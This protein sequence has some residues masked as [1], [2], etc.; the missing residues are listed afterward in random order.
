M[1]V[2]STKCQ[3]QSGQHVVLAGRL[4]N[5]ELT[6]VFINSI[7]R[8]RQ[9]SRALLVA[10]GLLLFAAESHAD[11]G[12]YVGGS[13]GQAGI[14]IDGGGP[15][16][17]I[18]FDEEDFAWKVFGGY[19]FDLAVVDLGIEI[20]Y[21]DLGAPSQDVQG[22]QVELEADGIDAFGVV[23]IALGPIGVF[24]KYG[25]IS[26]DAQGTID[27]LPAFDDDGSDPAYGVGAKIALGS[28]EIRLEYEIFDIDDTEDVALLSA[29]LVWNF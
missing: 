11:S 14:E 25:V 28:L 18:F 15:S 10:A 24:G 27:N 29:G 2:F 22:S 20:G 9:G 7:D 6:K 16:Q 1:R 26:W 5:E 19:N 12:L 13:V 21:V 23:G 4:G 8:N 3:Q 17:P